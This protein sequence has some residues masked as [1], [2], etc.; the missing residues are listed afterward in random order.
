MAA[1]KKIFVFVCLTVV[2]IVLSGCG[3]DKVPPELVIET[4]EISHAAGAD[5]VL[6]EYIKD[7][8]SVSD[9]VTAEDEIK[10][11]IVDFGG[12]D[13]GVKGTYEITIRATDKE[14]NYTD[15][16]MTVVVTDADTVPPAL[17]KTPTTIYHIAGEEVDL[18]EGLEGVDD[19]DGVNVNFK[20][21]DLGDYDRNV[22]GTYT[23][24]IVV[25]DN[26]GN[27]SAPFEREV[28][29][30]DSYSRAEMVSFEGEV[31][32]YEALYNPQILAGHTATG[33]NT[34]YDGHYVNVLSKDY[35]DWLVNYA[36]ERIGSGVGWSVIAVTD[37]DN[38]IVYVRHWNSGEA[39]LD[40]EGNLVSVPAVD[41][42]TGTNRNWTEE[43]NG[44][45]ISRTNARYSSGEMGMMMA[46]ISRWIPDGGHV[47]MFINWMTIGLDENEEVVT[48]ANTS[49]M[50]R[51]MGANYIMYSDEDGDDV[52]D[53]ALGRELKIIDPQLSKQSI[54]KSFDADKPFPVITVSGKRTV[55]DTGVWKTNYIETVYLNEHDSENPYDPLAGVTANDGKGGDITDEITYRVYRYATTEQVYGYMT[56]LSIND[57]RWAEYY[58][59][60][61]TLE[62]NE[63][64]LDNILVP[65]NDGHYFV[66]E[67]T[68]TANGHTDTLYR[69]IQIK[70][71]TPDYIELYGESDSVYANVMSI[72]QR[73]EM[74]PDLDEFGAMDNTD[75]GILYN[76]E[77][78]KSLSAYPN[79]PKGVVVV[80]DEYYRVL[81]I[82]V[83]ANTAFEITPDGKAEINDLDWV[84]DGLLA[85]ID[86]MLPEGGYVVIYPEGKD[87][88]VLAKALRAFV[89][90]DYQE[91]DITAD[92][93]NGA[94]SVSLV[95]KEVQEVSTLLVNGEAPLIEISGNEV[96]I[97]VVENSKEALIFY[98]AGGGAGFRL[99]TGKAYYFTKEMYAVLSQ[100]QEVVSSFTTSSPN[101]G[102][103]WF[104]DGS[105]VV[106]DADG[107]FVLARVMTTAAA[108]E[109]KADGTVIYGNAAVVATTEAD[110]AA[111]GEANLSFDLVIPNAANTV[112]H[113][114]LAD[115]LDIVPDGGSFIIFPGTANTAVRNYSV[116]LLWNADY[117][118][119]GIIV[120][121]T[122]EEPPAG[123]PD[124]A[125]N[126]FDFDNYT[127]DYFENLLIEVEFVATVA[128]KPAK[129][130]RPKV[131]LDGNAIS[132]A[133]VEGAA[134]YDLYVD[135]VLALA[136]AGTFNEETN[137]YE[138]DLVGLDLGAAT[139]KIQVRAITADEKASSTSVLSDAVMYELRRA[140][141]PDPETFVLDD[142]ILSWGEVEGATKYLVSINDGDYFEVETNQVTIP[143]DALT[144]GTIVKVIAVG[145][146]GVFNSLPTEYELDIEVIPKEITLGSY[147]LPVVEFTASAWLRHADPEKG[148]DPGAQWIQGIVVVNGVHEFA[149][150]DDNVRLFSGGY[151]AVLDADFKVKYIVDRWA[152]EW[153]A[154]DGWT[155]NSGGWDWALHFY[156]SYFK[157]YLEE[158]DVIIFASQYG[159]G[160]PEGTYRNYF[161]NALIYDLETLTTDH[162]NINIEEAIDPSAVK[163]E[164]KEVVATKTIALGGNHLPI[165]E[166]TLEKWLNYADP[167]GGNDVGAANIAGIVL[168]T[169]VIGIADLEDN[170]RLFSGGYA[171]VLDA[172]LKV[173]YI[174]DRWAHEWNAEDGW[175]TNSGGWDWALNF[176][177]SYFKPYLEEGDVIIFASQYGKGLPAGTYRNYF[178]NALIK[179]LGTVTT[180]H[181]GVDLEEAIDP[182][183]ANIV[184]REQ[185][186]V[187]NVGT[188]LVNVKE[189]ELDEWLNYADPTGG[190]DVGAR[191]IH[192]LVLVHGAAGIKELDD[193]AVVFS[194]GYVAV[195][196]SEF[197]VKY[198]VDRWAHEWN[199]EDGWTVNDGGWG[200]ALNLKAS[201]FKPYLEDGDML[202]MASQYGVG[203]GVGT[204]RNVLGNELIYNLGTLTTDHRNV[205]I[206]EALDPSEVAIQ[207]IELK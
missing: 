195:V 119:S 43:V 187:L 174:V 98:P 60:V 22:P 203:L 128:D 117:P 156:A 65:G 29:V 56:S 151:A 33:Y 17:T 48:K 129:L 5:I 175:T 100:S 158:G 152:H 10:I 63:V 131:T 36:P 44:K 26:A 81:T 146:E 197:K 126:G 173:K 21:V 14:G 184:I 27:E 86:D 108:A 45:M 64:Q 46:N 80:L 47:F 40:N 166:F 111:A 123:S 2:A 11:E 162:R 147:V 177:A 122:A 192:G 13:K 165:V 99:D 205:D 57:P 109:I 23:V 160:L 31:I 104:R 135:G 101:K 153:N 149:N 107:K 12:Y 125:T 87:G 144:A 62:E 35:V 53:Y 55:T 143:D 115:I 170:H 189:M 132:W 113:G 201:Y 181:R 59:E 69:L 105:I 133:A 90:F 134:S 34:A 164:I 103:P 130:P 7:F 139:Y 140:D 24:M 4:P 97:K 118:G 200:W 85:G 138:F 94:V 178:G 106:L 75:K 8:I 127:A 121:A 150:L 42:S 102:V 124:P 112:P 30:S 206:E 16:K 96:T 70:A 161:G 190:N 183:A 110:K 67:Y 51:A 19:V 155:T 82:R 39:Y 191:W 1:F 88:T 167:D 58:D 91:G 95:I 25:Y 168:V 68:V 141:S 18:T 171:A 3:K 159:T 116:R 179:N 188:S 196:D 79:L 207:L 163:I 120:D 77:G 93:K 157:P 83:L 9:N 61:W 186:K 54:R 136:S 92:I 169:G 142:N 137:A 185:K 202:I 32:R 37:A 72:Q 89:D 71:D 194:G 145:E 176:Y 198:F 41:W 73:L 172:D 193:D 15:K 38:K 84:D 52:M 20:V 182:S 148:N 180:D 199:A 78:F 6:A 50:P 28:V 204:Y 76:Y 154:E 114:P 49:D 66:I 74:N